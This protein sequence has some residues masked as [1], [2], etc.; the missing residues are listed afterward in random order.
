VN[1]NKIMTPKEAMRGQKPYYLALTGRI[2]SWLEDEYSR[3][4]ASCTVFSVEDSMEGRNG[5]EDSWAFTSHGLRNAA[6]IALD[7][8]KLRPRGTDNGKGLIAS[9]VPSFARFYSLQ[10]EELR[11]GGTFKNGAVTLFL[12]ADHSDLRDF[13]LMGS[14]L[15][16]AKR[17]VYLTLAD[18]NELD[19]PT[20]KLLAIKVNNG[21]VWLAKKRWDDNGI[22]LRSNVCLEVAIEHRATCMLSSHNLGKEII[23][24]KIPQHMKQSMAYLC[25]LQS[26]TPIGQ[27][28]HY[29][30]PDMDKQV[31]LG[32][33]GLAN[34][35]AIHKVSYAD[36]TDSLERVVVNKGILGKENTYG[37]VLAQAI[38]EGHHE[39]AEVARQ[40]GMKRAFAVAPTASMSYR[41]KDYD[42]YT[43]TPEISPPIAKSLDR[44]SDTFGVTTHQYHPKVET[45]SEVGWGVYWRLVNAWQRMMDSTGL[46]HAISTNLWTSFT[47]T[48]EWIEKKFLPSDIWTTYYRLPIDQ[49][50]LDK[51]EVVTRE[52][53]EEKLRPVYDFEVEEE[54]L[55]DFEDLPACGLDDPQYCSSCG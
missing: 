20:Q 18:W 30:T 51:S 5:I 15:P 29:L 34:F 26:M 10:N 54:D 16:W 43:T 11:R 48:P 41:N 25:R 13:L 42:G 55:F 21:E 36:F 28:G 3:L 27:K 23:P 45:A 38:Y 52:S 14:D 49:H 47:V 32:V 53:D 37:D 40:Y 7:L 9:G 31:G 17:A 12:D 39:S 8:S 35:L 33:I 46:S 1:S 44:D 4:P 22:R 6:G 50:A 2:E 24:H 19:T